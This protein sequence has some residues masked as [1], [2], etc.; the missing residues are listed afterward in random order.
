LIP[1]QV[2]RAVPRSLQSPDAYSAGGEVDIIPPQITSLANPK[3]V[4]IDHQPNQPIPM[5]MAIS[6]EGTE[7]LLDLCLCE[8]LPHSVFRVSLAHWSHNGV[9]G[10]LCCC[11]IHRE[12]CLLAGGVATD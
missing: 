6:L 10:S 12:T 2:V 11:A 3:A 7:E 9:F 8:V 5:A 4:A 1:L